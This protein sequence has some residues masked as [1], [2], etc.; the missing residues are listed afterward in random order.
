M[1]SSR[2]A[3][4]DSPTGG[5]G[6]TGQEATRIGRYEVLNRI[7]VGGMAEVFR[8]R[9]TGPRGYQRNLIIKRIL[10]HFAAHP[11]F[12]RA[13]VDEAKILGM[14][15]HPNIVGIYDFGEDN[16]RHYLALEYL[17]GPSLAS[18][19]ARMR[20]AKK[21]LPF[22]VVAFIAREVCR[23]L[24]AVHSL[25]D[26][27]GKPMNVIHRD[28]TPSNV[29]TTTGGAVK[30]LDFGIAKISGSENVTRVGHIKGKAGYLAPEQILGGAVDGRV[31]LFSLGVVLYEMLRLEPL[32]YG[33]GGDVGAV[34]RTLEK[35]IDPPSSFRS[36]VPAE[37][38]QSVM[39]ALAREP[40]RRYQTAVEM[41]RDL[42]AAFLISGLL[43]EDV[44]QILSDIRALPPA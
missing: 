34:Y 42:D 11:D 33:E 20:N 23:G 18:I 5:G 32:F 39:K 43:P 9:A 17:D 15:Y 13:F 28:V 6:S 41:E 3:I 27:S 26:P 10:P 24:I 12:V 22:G 35:K 14:L 37:F 2:T 4:P 40:A 7:G 21:T 19:L 25:R 30:L 38:E 1:S 36:D 8:A 16:D 31:D 44:A 29:M